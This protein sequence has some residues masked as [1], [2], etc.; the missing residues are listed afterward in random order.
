MAV[1]LV[2][3]SGI[4]KSMALRYDAASK[5]ELRWTLTQT[6]GAF[7][8]YLPCCAS[9][10]AAERLA[11]AIED[12]QHIVITSGRLCYRKRATKTGEQSR[13]EILVW[14]AE[15]LAAS[16]GPTQ[17]ETPACGSGFDEAACH[18]EAPEPVPGHKPR[19]RAL[20]KH[21]QQPLVASRLGASEN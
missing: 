1:N 3:A 15:V 16:T 18:S 7:S 9:G 14:Q 12:G 10:A 13:L 4:V 19:K 21:R 5:P 11:S 20:P 2:V 6:D 8:L 17:A